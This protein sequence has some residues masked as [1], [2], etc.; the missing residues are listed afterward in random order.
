MKA[1]HFL[2]EQKQTQSKQRDEEQQE[3]QQKT[4][5]EERDEE[6][7]EKQ[8]K[9][10]DEKQQ[11]KKQKTTDEERDEEQQEKLIANKHAYVS[12]GHVLFAVDSYREYG[13][14]SGR[15]LDELGSVS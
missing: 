8:Q 4:T 5:D 11:E 3:K 12:E 2:R 9:T 1:A 10:T 14:L 7:Q 15:K 13:A 6:Q